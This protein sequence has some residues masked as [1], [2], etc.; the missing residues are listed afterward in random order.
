MT[1]RK[2]SNG[3][4]TGPFPKCATGRFSLL[5]RAFP[6]KYVQ[7][8]AFS[9]RARGLEAG[10]NPLAALS[11]F[12]GKLFALLVRAVR[13]GTLLATAM[14]ARAFGTGPRSH[15]RVSRWRLADTVLVAA[16]TIDSLDRPLSTYGYTALRPIH[17]FNVG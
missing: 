4:L 17:I 11:I 3:I 10:R 5:S 14:D 7:I 15:A 2:Q 8:T 12:F 1:E 13:T 6:I 16:H 9:D